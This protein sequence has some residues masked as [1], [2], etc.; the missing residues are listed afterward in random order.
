MMKQSLI[1]ILSGILLFSCSTKHYDHPTVKIGTIFG[2]IY[3]ELYPDK[4]PLSTGTF[5][6]NVQDRVYDES[7]FYRVLKADEQPISAP[8]VDLIQGGIFFSRP[9]ISKEK[10]GI[11]LETTRQ[12]GLI[13]DDGTISFAR[14]TPE[15]GGLEFFICMGR[16]SAYDYGGTASSDGLG[17]AA[18]GK[19]IEGMPVVRKIHNQTSEGEYFTPPVRI[20]YIKFLNP[21]K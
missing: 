21:S 20:K 7:N 15:S 6:K 19:V 12:T 9:A 8:K 11:P 14:T 4:A 1:F 3:V 18:F 17:Y 10:S 13:H 5:L 16:L 2:D